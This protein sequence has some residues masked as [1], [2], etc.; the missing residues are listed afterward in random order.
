VAEVTAVAVA[1]TLITVTV[2][3]KTG[4]KNIF[5]APV[6]GAFSLYFIN[7]FSFMDR[8]SKQ[9]TVGNEQRLFEFTRLENI[10]GVKFFITSVDENKKPFSFSVRRKDAN[11]WRLL[12]GSQRW[13][14]EIE[15]ELS[16]AIS[17]TRLK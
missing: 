7:K 5:K 10:N 11:N 8:F 6:I 12:P 1:A 4:T 16:N 14:Y 3:T 9:I 2:I 17:E 15:E 13:L